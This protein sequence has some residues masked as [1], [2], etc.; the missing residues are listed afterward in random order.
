MEYLLYTETFWSRW[1]A[2]REKAFDG[3]FRKRKSQ[4]QDRRSW[5]GKG[6]LILGKRKRG[7]L[8]EFGRSRGCKLVSVRI[9]LTCCWILR[10]LC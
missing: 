9:E 1:F 5:R 6:I 10:S 8:R 4:R 7:L 2:G 3:D